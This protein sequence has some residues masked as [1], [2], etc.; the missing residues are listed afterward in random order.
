[1]TTRSTQ[2]IHHP[3]QAPTAFEAP[4]IGVFKASTVIFPDTASMRSRP[5]P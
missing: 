5:P 2:L 1:M 3:Y 4:Q